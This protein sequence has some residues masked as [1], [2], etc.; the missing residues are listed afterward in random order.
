[1]DRLRE[2]KAFL[3]KGKRYN[4][5]AHKTT[6]FMHVP[7]KQAASASGGSFLWGYDTKGLANVIALA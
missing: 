3:D 2:Q 6:S 1:M 5:F 4:D 7:A